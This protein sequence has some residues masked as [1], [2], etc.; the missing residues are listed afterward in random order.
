MSGRPNY[1]S[2][3]QISESVEALRVAHGLL[4]EVPVDIENFTEN[5][6]G[7]AIVPEP[8]VREEMGADAFITRDFSSI[9]IDYDYFL[10]RRMLFRNRFS[11]A[12]E[13]G[14]FYLHREY[15]MEQCPSEDE[16]AWKDFMR[17][18]PD[19]AFASLEWQANTF[20]SLLLVPRSHLLSRIR[21]EATF[22]AL[23][24]TYEVSTISIER[25]LKAEDIR[26]AL[27]K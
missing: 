24:R 25:R 22:E 3:Q 13:L 14:H 9:L 20:A 7:I 11:I 8:G 5:V 12:H 17:N 6:L 18:L 16:E 19:I 4:S 27:A 26:E 21:E 10:D 15:F 23:S 1:L 2:F